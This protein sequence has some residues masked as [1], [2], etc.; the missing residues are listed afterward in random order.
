[1]KRRNEAAA[2]ALFLLLLFWLVALGMRQGRQCDTGQQPCRQRAFEHFEYSL[3]DLRHFAS[4]SNQQG[5]TPD[6]PAGW[7]IDFPIK[8]QDATA[9]KTGC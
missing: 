7:P 6:V 1:L 8:S 2:A 4:A 9:W 5:V 3:I